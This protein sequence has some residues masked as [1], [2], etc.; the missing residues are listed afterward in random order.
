ME[1]VKAPEIDFADHTEYIEL[2]TMFYRVMQAFVRARVNANISFWQRWPYMVCLDL[3]DIG[4]LFMLRLTKGEGEA[5]C[6]QALREIEE[7][8]QEVISGVI[9]FGRLRGTPVVSQD[10]KLVLCETLSHAISA[11]VRPL[12]VKN[13]VLVSH[14]VHPFP[15]YVDHATSMLYSWPQIFAFRL[16]VAMGGHRRLGEASPIAALDDPIIRLIVIEAYTPKWPFF[17][18]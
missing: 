3:R 11:R 9:T 7:L 15:G 4:T 5:W 17:E 2:E 14:P 13:I 16:A 10:L 6:G 1:L 8:V 18:P 12:L